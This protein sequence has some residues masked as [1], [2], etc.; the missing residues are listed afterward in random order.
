M[1]ENKK[2]TK[3]VVRRKK[4]KGRRSGLETIRATVLYIVFVLAVSVLLSFVA[5]KLS[6]DMFAF[7]KEDRPVTIVLPEDATLSE[8]VDIVVENGLVDYGTL[9]KFFVN[10][11][12]SGSSF[13]EGTHE[14]NENLDYRGLLNELAKSTAE[15]SYV[16][17][18]KVTIPEGYTLEQIAE[19]MEEK[20]VVTYDDFIDTAENYE[21]SHEFLSTHED[22]YYQLEGFLFPDTYEF[23][24][25]DSA[26]SVINKLLNNFETR[27]WEIIDS[28]E[29]YSEY[30]V[31]LFELV[32]IAS[33][34][35][36][37]AAKSEEQ[38]TIAG[39]IYNRLASSSYPFLNI[40]A[41]IQYAAGHRENILQADLDD[42]G[43]YNTYTRTGLPAGPIANP[44]LDALQAAFEPEEHGY[45]FYVAESDGYHIFTTNLS[46]H[47]A[48][49]ASV[50]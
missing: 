28:L 5:I 11:S 31:D 41:T 4:R 7:V 34:V 29:E 14:V 36:R 50:R 35:E 21:F 48:A 38:A 27:T 19:L 17:T 42:D 1:E 25:N 33:L 3:P 26:V 43:P 6:N 9:F 40:D 2:T 13:T 10:I 22:V 47:N 39:V 8:V 12:A 18:I 16:E 44:G 15:S 23:Y 20:G 24:V 45:Y 46:D 37:E 49:V 30:D 32:T